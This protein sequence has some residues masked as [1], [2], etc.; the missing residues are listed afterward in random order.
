MAAHYFNT[1][2]NSQTGKP[3]YNA[4]VSVL[5]G[6]SASGGALLTLYSDEALSV[7]TDNPLTTDVTGFFEFYTDQNEC[8]LEIAY[9]GETKRVLENVQLIG[10]SVSTDI[11]ALSLRMDTAEAD[12]VALQGDV[13]ALEK[14]IISIAMVGTATAGEVLTLHPVGAPF[15][16]PANFG[17]GALETLKGANPTATAD[18]LVEKSTDSG[19]TW[20]TVG[21]LSVST[22]GTVTATT[23]GGAAI[24]YSKGHG[25]RVSAPANADATFASW[26]FTIIG[27]R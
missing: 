24:S 6:P 9:D 8:C 27:V 19:A 26:S 21:T 1:V 12:I 25:L 11:T 5:T 4:S 3:V 10:G 22:G 23:S 18:V 17:S 2:E 13:A 14:Y 16:I 7:T 15:T 20:S